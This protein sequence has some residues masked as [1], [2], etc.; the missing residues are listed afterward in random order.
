MHT[1]K[2]RNDVKWE[3]ES[4][5]LNPLRKKSRAIAAS[6]G[7]H[8]IE[9]ARAG[10]VNVLI[11]L[12]N[13]RYRAN[14]DDRNINI[15][16]DIN[17]NDCDGRPTGSFQ[18]CTFSVIE[19]A[20]KNSR[21][22]SN[23]GFSI[24]FAL[25][26]TLIKTA[27]PHKWFLRDKFQR[28]VHVPLLSVCRFTMQTQARG[29]VGGTESARVCVYVIYQPECD[30]FSMFSLAAVLSP[31]VTDTHRTKEQH[32]SP[33]LRRICLNWF[34]HNLLWNVRDLHKT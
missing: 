10:A 15:Q 24:N 5:R 14:N 34:F 1:N 12:N 4:C 19:N 11:C 22:S 30:G 8:I 21:R 20:Q 29:R 32:I 28:T 6:I 3:T 16:H 31:L 2:S 33:R 7:L 23:W 18:S 25:P 27:L 26:S 9:Y 17:K 13:R